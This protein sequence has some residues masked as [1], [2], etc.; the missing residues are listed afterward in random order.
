MAKI[1]QNNLDTIAACRYCPM[2]RQSCPSE[3]ISYRESDTPRGRAILL[4]NIYKGG[5]EFDR[6]A[7]EAV[8]NC[9]L[10]ISC[11]SWCEGYNVK[12]YD[13]PELIKFARRDIVEK[14]L[15]PKIIEQIKISLVE[16]NNSFG[17]DSSEAFTAQ[18]NGKETGDVLYLLGEG[19]NYKNKEIAEA[20]ISILDKAGIDYA[21]LKDEPESGKILD[22]LGYRNEAQEKAKVLEGKIK[23]TGCKTVVVSD[24]LTYDVFMKDYPEWGLNLEGIEVMHVSQYLEKL[25]SS[26]KLKVNQSAVKVTLA[27]SEYLGRSNGVWDS[28]RE[29]I[30]SVAGDNYVE[31]Q[32]HHDYLQP[33]GEA[34]FTFDDEM[35]T[36]GEELGKKISKKAEEAGA[37]VIVTLSATAKRNILP[38]TDIKVV[39][40]AEYVGLV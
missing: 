37:E 14:G 6:T 33:A 34:A 5:K 8:Y 20:V 2:C 10:C 9:F 22:L 3:F 26:G 18:Q 23:A 25:I 36:R 16:N 28:P 27:D 31:M 4:Y 17:M 32:W 7:I 13:I 30:K 40:I 19:V 15:A 12:G 29:V 39:D 24:P 35:F 1:T 38:T 21:L 11:R